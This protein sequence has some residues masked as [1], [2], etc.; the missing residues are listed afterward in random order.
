M[1][2][3]IP[4]NYLT[5]KPV[6]LQPAERSGFKTPSPRSKERDFASIVLIAKVL[7]RPNRCVAN[8]SAAFDKLRP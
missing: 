5:D 1:T 4:F 7:R 8:G 2:S 6:D 3:C